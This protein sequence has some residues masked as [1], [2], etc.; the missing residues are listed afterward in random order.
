V[1]AATDA[2]TALRVARTFTPDV[3]F[4]DLAMPRLDGLELVRLLR[5][6]PSWEAVFVIALSGRTTNADIAGAREAGCDQ[7]LMK[8]QAPEK[9]KGLLEDLRRRRDSSSTE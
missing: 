5:S 2:S 8:P 9:I 7:Y 4:I 3:A 6:V 1:Q